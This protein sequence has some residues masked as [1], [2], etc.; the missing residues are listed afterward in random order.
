M[1]HLDIAGVFFE[2]DSVHHGATGASILSI[3][4]CIKSM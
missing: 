1:I 4:E 2:E 3:F